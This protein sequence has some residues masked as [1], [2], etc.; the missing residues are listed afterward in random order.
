[1]HQ[2][3]FYKYINT[4]TFLHGNNVGKPIST[5][6]E[7]LLVTPIELLFMVSSEGIYHSCN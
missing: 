6:D 2:L 5:W 4:L 3:F 1:M 7:D